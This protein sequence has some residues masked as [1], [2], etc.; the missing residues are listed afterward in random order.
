MTDLCMYHP[1]TQFIIL[2]EINIGP[3]RMRIAIPST[4]IEVKVADETAVVG[5]TNALTSIITKQ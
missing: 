4:L 5:G 3:F 2:I 1:C